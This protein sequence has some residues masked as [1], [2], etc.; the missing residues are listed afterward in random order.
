VDVGADDKAVGQRRV[1]LME[2]LWE[3]CELDLDE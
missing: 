1:K 3:S 2:I